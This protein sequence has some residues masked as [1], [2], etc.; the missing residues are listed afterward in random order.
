MGLRALLIALFFS[1]TASA[2]VIPR[3][4]DRSD[5][6]QVIRLLGLST[7]TKLLTNPFPLGGYSGFEVGLSLELIDVR[8]LAELGITSTDGDKELRYP[9]LT[10]GK[11]LYNNIDMFL[12]F[13][14]QTAGSELTSFGG[15]VRYS[16]YEAQFL[17]VNISAVLSADHVNVNDQFES[18]TLGAELIAGLYINQFS[19][20][21]GV[22][23]LRSS[24]T[25]IAGDLA[26]PVI[27]DDVTVDINDPDVNGSTRTVE[28]T[29]N[30]IHTMA[31]ITVHFNDVFMAA[32]I[33]RYPDPVYSA[34]LGLRF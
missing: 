34:R 32:Q 25:F 27:P 10:I 17:P 15:A 7:S 12:H 20:Y 24:G 11:G 1:S 18:M 23:Q 2:V 16:F 33:D 13:A 22:G 14:P 4:L 28:Q 3:D 6:D 19:L 30:Q 8:D 21:M 29:V 9:R 31:G 5:R 26:Q